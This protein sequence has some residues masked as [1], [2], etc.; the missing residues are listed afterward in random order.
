MEPISECQVDLFADKLPSIEVIKE[1][2]GFVHSSESNLLSFR[3]QLE[4]GLEKS[5]PKANLASG[6][7]LY[8]A[9]RTEDATKKLQ[10]AKDCKEK[11][12]YL[13]LAFRRVGNY[14]QA[15]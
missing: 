8:I 9:G 4:A 10:K 11:Y 2:S 15:I 14:G 6:I 1:L 7:G 12:I 13:A 5:S 3:E